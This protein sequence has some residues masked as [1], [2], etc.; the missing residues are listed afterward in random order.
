MEVINQPE[1]IVLIE[2]LNSFVH[3]VLKFL[4]LNGI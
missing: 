4:N 2:A 3:S 1:L